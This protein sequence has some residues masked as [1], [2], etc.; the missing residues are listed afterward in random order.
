MSDDRPVLVVT[1]HVPP[2]RAGAF[3]ALHEREGIELALFGGRSHHA[4]D[5]VEDPG[6][7]HRAVAQRDVFALAASGAYRAVICGTA[8][9]VA[10]PAAWL[11]ARRAR[12]PFV[13]WTALWAHPR[14][15]AHLL[16][17]APLLR[18]IY[19]S[20]DA[21]VTY[22]P[23]VS[24]FVARR[25]ARNV[26]V[27]PQAVDAAFWSAPAP[28]PWRPE[29]ASFVALSVGRA[30]RYKGVPELLEAWRAAALRPPADA[31]VLVGERTAGEP[32]APPGVHPVGGQDATALR[33]F[34]GGAD[35]LVMPAIATR[36]TLEPWGLV[37]NEAMHQGLPVI[38]TTA[39]GAAAGGL[40][41]HERNGL[42]VPA[43]DASALAGALRRLRD[44][45]A[46][47]ARLGAA[48]AEDV[49]GHTFAAWATGMSAALVSVRASRHGGR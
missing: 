19:R 11:G 30:A 12:V 8:G 20:A 15:P 23:H 43:G 14:T 31:L 45:P 37:A 24:A 40:V 13:L 1:N 18:A 32:P 35:V 49:A 28:A 27:A 42:V 47:R 7:P 4:T 33:N 10:L 3:R 21:V 16:A 36:E 2:D 29:G 44:D 25:G 48:A 17:G 6:V 41:R 39:V 5:A 46:L 34:Y 9:R 26:H 38:A 22:G